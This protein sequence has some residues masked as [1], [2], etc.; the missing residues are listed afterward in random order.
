MQLFSSLTVVKPMSVKTFPA[1][2]RGVSDDTLS[3]IIV[4]GCRGREAHQ[5]GD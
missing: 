3:S 2:V 4:Q 5:I 1:E